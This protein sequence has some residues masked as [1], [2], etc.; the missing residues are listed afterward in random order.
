MKRRIPRRRR[1]AAIVGGVAI[2][3]IVG[4]AVAGYGLGN[5]GGSAS[6]TTAGGTPHFVEQTAGSGLSHTYGG[7]DAYVVGGGVAVFD[8]NGDGRP[9]IYLAGGSNP[10]AV[11]RNDSPVG[12]KTLTFTRIPDAAADLTGVQGAYPIDIDG[13]GNVDLVVLRLGE[14]ELLRGLGGCRFE[15]A[16]ARWS[17]DGGNDYA[18]A[19][20]ATWEG[21]NALPTLA[22]GHYLKLDATGNPTLDCAESELVRP[23]ADGTGFDRPIALSPGYCALSMLFSD[24]DLSGRRDLRVSNDRNYYVNGQDQL[25]R[26]APG[27]APRAYTDADGWVSLQIFGMGIAEYD[28]NGDGYPDYYLTSQADNRLQTLATGPDQPT[29]RDIAFKRGVV[30][31]RP[32]SG[33]QDLPSTSWHPEF[34]DVNNDGFIDLLVSKGNVAVQPGFATKDPSDLFLG[35]P[36]GNFKQQAEAAGIVEYDRGR[37]AALADFNMDGLL[38]LIEVHYDAPARVWLNAGS[39]ASGEP[40]QMGHWLALRPVQT[41]PNVDAVGA[42]IEVKVGDLTLR[43][44]LTIGGGHAGGQL[45]WIHF[46][47]GP[48]G[49]AQVRVKWPDGQ[50]GPWLQVNANQFLDIVRGATEARPWSPPS[51]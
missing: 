22:I 27:E 39:A 33:G 26:V 15:K 51:A 34:E 23:K 28:V 25:W 47:L 44:E 9:D 7:G 42:W 41:G 48:A 13:D 50:V 31:T 14:T 35:Q 40:A 2:V 21:S 37:G 10:A 38:D 43:R 36:D 19:F 24:W 49:S 45:G 3:A 8:C 46:G 1:T 16:N 5:L 17:F 4:V 30:S 29:Y 12:G 11:Y 32:G 18:T 20:S 6:P